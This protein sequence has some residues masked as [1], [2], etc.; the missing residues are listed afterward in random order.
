[1]EPTQRYW[2]RAK[3]FGWGWGPP[4]TWE[5]WLTLVV[6]VL[7]VLG[8]TALLPERRTAS[9]ATVV[10]ATLLLLWVCL[11]KGEPTRWRW[12]KR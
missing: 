7:V 8:A 6:Y 11:E 5:G 1:M 12:S 4:K 3:R 2:F 10:M 9:L